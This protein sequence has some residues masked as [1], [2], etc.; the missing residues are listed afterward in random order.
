MRFSIFVEVVMFVERVAAIL[1]RVF[2]TVAR[3]AAFRESI[4]HGEFAQD[5]S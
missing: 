4:L 2:G 5:Y 3:I 1:M